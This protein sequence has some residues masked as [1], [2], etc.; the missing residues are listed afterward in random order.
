M[1]EMDGES[2]DDMAT[3]MDMLGVDADTFEMIK[4][5]LETMYDDHS[6]EP[7]SYDDLSALL[8]DF[9]VAMT[10]DMYN[11]YTAV[12]AE[13]GTSEFEDQVGA[14]LN[15][16]GCDTDTCDM[17]MGAIMDAMMGDDMYYDMPSFEDYVEYFEAE[18]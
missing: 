5:E 16:V 3:L 2:D 9:N 8:A 13:E 10:D 17:I 12:E 7:L 6:M 14:F 18:Y 15:W 11:A 4:A 1:F